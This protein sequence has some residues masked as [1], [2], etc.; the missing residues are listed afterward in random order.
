MKKSHNQKQKLNLKKIKITKL[1]NFKH[2]KGG[3]Q[4]FLND[5]GYNTDTFETRC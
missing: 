3:A 5:T 2:I 1:N 4:I